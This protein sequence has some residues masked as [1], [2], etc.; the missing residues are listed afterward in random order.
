MKNVLFLMEEKQLLDKYL[1]IVENYN[2]KTTGFTFK[3]EKIFEKIEKLE[4][5]DIA[6]IEI[7]ECNLEIKEIIKKIKEKFKNCKILILIPEMNDTIENF[8]IDFSIDSY[9]IFPFLP[10]QLLR[11]IFLLDNL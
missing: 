4:N 8:I 1:F 2:Y 7:N 11:A 6:V 3:D 5:V 10:F 9:L